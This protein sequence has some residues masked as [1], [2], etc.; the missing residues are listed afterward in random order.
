MKDL[1]TLG[2]R[3]SRAYGLNDGGWVVGE[4]ADSNGIQHAFLWRDGIMTSLAANAAAFAINDAG[5]AAGMADDRAAW[6]TQPGAPA[7]ILTATGGVGIAFDL[8]GASSVVGQAELGDGEDRVSRA[9]VF[10]RG[11]AAGLAD[12]GRGLSSSAQAVNDA[13]Q[14]A[15]FLESA[16]GRT[17]A[18]LFDT[19]GLLDVD[20][21][22]NAYSAAYGLNRQGML[23]GVMFNSPSDDD[24]AF[25][26][27]AGDMFNLNDLLD[28]REQW[29]L[30]EAR[31]INDAGQIVGY[32][33]ENDLERAFLLTPLEGNGGRLP[34]ARIAQP[35][36][37]S[38]YPEPATIEL[39]AD[40]SSESGIR[41]VV[42]YANGEVLGTTTNPPGRFVWSDAPAGDY[43]LVARAFDM[44]GQMGVSPRVRVRIAVTPGRA[45]ASDD[46]PPPS[47]RTAGEPEPADAP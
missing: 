17:H 28:T 30:V 23:V 32:G 19:N 44:N 36:N 11:V 24:Q 40:A 2:G 13:G 43:D 12:L 5:A 6:W 10:S 16:R 26:W 33:I 34:R 20:T 22:N 9:F 7:T 1:G 47:A 41:R 21:L 39:M 35:E 31:D 14:I 8:N 15:G 18:F 4:A 42:F 38:E 45:P 3:T 29:A 27:S 37:N 46:M 25:L